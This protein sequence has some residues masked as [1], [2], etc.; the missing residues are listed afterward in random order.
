MNTFPHVKVSGGPRERGRAYGEQARERI[1]ISISAYEDVFLA[2]A[3]WDWGRVRREAAGYEGSIAA[4]DPRYVEEMRGIAEGAEV[5]LEDVTLLNARTE[6]L[7]LAERP[8]FRAQLHADEQDACTGVVALPEVT[9]RGR[10]I[11]AQNWDWKAE[12]AETAV[13]LRVR[14]DDG[15]DLLTFTEAGGLARSG[16]NAAGIA[17]TAN[18]L[19]SNRDYCQL[20]VPLALIRRKVLES[21]HLAL[22]MR[23]VYVTPKSASNNMIVSH[24]GGIAID[25]ECAPDETFQVPPERGLLVHANH[26]VSPVALAKLRDTGIANTPCTLYRDLRVRGLLAPQ[27]PGLTREAVKTALTDDFASPWSVCRPP[28]RS[29]QGNLTATVATIVMEPA[30]GVMEVAPLPALECEFTT[31]TLEPAAAAVTR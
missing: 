24:A 26:W 2:Y 5:P 27:I 28:R 30:A 25:F 19:E 18:Y 6:I 29:L 14:R 1:G 12:C 16:F 31:Y 20:G 22:A 9:E 4:F 21:E 15:P 10:L 23:A 17:I 7:K 3:G 11:H 13:V 8:D